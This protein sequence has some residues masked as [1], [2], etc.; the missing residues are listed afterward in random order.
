MIFSLE[1]AYMFA[2]GS[3]SWLSTIDDLIMVIPYFWSYILCHNNDRIPKGFA[4]NGLYLAI[5]SLLFFLFSLFE[6]RG[7]FGFYCMVIAGILNIVLR[8]IWLFYAF[9]IFKRME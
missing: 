3:F 5:L 7:A 8:F 4:R 6:L 9:S 1:I 2:R